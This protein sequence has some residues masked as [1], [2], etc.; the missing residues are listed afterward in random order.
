LWSILAGLFWLPRI[1]RLVKADAP[2]LLREDSGFDSARLLFAKA[3][4]SAASP[5]G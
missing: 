5:A 4:P 2:V 1:E 3:P